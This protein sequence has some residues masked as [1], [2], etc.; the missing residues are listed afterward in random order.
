MVPI[1]AMRMPLVLILTAVSLVLAMLVTPVMALFVATS[2][3]VLWAQTTVTPTLLA[4]IIVAPLA[5][6]VT[7]AMPVMAFLAVIST[8]VSLATI[9]VTPMPRVLTMTEVSAVLATP[10]TLGTV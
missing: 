10:A 3:S 5:A 2:M 1:T 4:R 8:S 7:Q 6:H 9:T